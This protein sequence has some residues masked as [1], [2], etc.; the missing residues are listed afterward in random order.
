MVDKNTNNE[1]DDYDDGKGNENVN[2]SF[3]LGLL[4][5]FEKV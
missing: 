5:C 1:N 4:F 3:Q 2:R